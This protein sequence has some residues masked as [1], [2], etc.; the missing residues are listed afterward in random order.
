[1][2]CALAASFK[3]VDRLRAK[4]MLPH[5]PLGAPPDALLARVLC[6]EPELF[7]VQH[8]LDATS[9]FITDDVVVA[10]S[11]DRLPS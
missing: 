1:M 11:Q 5:A 4:G 7:E 8:S 10:K 6:V 9:R 2:T 3:E